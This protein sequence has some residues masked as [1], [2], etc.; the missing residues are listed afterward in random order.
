MSEAA[1]LTA[2]V[3]AIRASTPDLDEHASA[4]LKR[5]LDDERAAQAVAAITD[6][7]KVAIRVVLSC[8][9]CEEFCRTFYSFV[10]DEIRMVDH[11]DKLKV[12]TEDLDKLITEIEAG[13]R[14][15]FAAWITL[16]PGEAD[17]LHFALQQARGLIRARRQIAVQTPPRLGA[18]QK[19]KTSDESNAIGWLAASIE[20]A[21]GRP[22]YNHVA[23][24]A[25]ITLRTAEI[26]EADRVRETLRK[27]HRTDWRQA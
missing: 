2:A 22:H 13:P 17:Y 16:Q 3:E 26:V 9:S 21:T 10:T 11:L 14:N 12:A 20:R 5:L 4:V 7:P 27:R 18:T 15:Q 6:D 25:E 1:F 24:L 8:I 23:T 19:L